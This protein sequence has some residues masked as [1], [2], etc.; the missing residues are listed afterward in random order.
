[1]EQ[2]YL[3]DSNQ[4]ARRW[5][6][7]KIC[8]LVGAVYCCLEQYI[9]KAMQIRP[10]TGKI[11]LRELQT[12]RL[13][14]NA[15]CEADADRFFALKSDPEVTL[16]YFM[17]PL[18][19]EASDR[20]LATLMA[21]SEEGE[22]LCW[23][24]RKKDAQEFIGS[25]VLWNLEPEKAQAEVGYELIPEYHGKGFAGEALE[26]VL[27]EAFLALG[28]ERVVALPAK[29]NL[30]SRRLLEGHGFVEAGV[31]EE[32]GHLMVIYLRQCLVCAQA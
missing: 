19:R 18:T 16:P 8:I 4:P 29:Q 17:Q 10:A 20:K 28:F 11:K 14:L 23:A 9:M 30:P 24:I 7:V 32:G 1:M 15:L 27:A 12:E 13:R 5:N 31:M 6:L 22:S 3:W 26:A 25:M 21:E 2:L